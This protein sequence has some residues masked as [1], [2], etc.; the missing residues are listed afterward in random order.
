MDLRGRRAFITGA[1]SGIG[2][3][4]ARLLAGAGCDLVLLARRGPRLAELAGELRRAGGGRIEA[5]AADVRDNAQLTKLR[6]REPRLFDEVDILLNNAGKAKGFDPVHEGR[7]AHWEEMID[8]NLR[9]LLY[10]TRLVLPGMVRRGAGHVINVGSVAGH[11]VYPKGAVYCAT[12]YAVR[13][14]SEGL[15]QDLLGS[16]VRVTEIAPGLVETE[17][18]EVRFDGDGARAKEVYRGM[19]PLSAEDVAQAVLWC[20]QRPAHVNVQ[21]LVLFPTDQA[22]VTNVHRRA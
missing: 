21:S 10:V 6:E 17:F 9:G 22:S 7:L 1:S 16:G 15:R 5:L 18:A 20:M 8:T 19:T 13:A 11:W 12:K 14:F 4:C 2:R 3:A